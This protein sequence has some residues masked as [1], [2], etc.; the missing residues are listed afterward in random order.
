MF[1]PGKYSCIR[2]SS[3]FALFLRIQRFIQWLAS[4]VF[5]HRRLRFPPA[6]FLERIHN[7]PPPNSL[8]LCSNWSNEPSVFVFATSIFFSDKIFCVVDLSFEITDGEGRNVFDF[9]SLSWEITNASEE[10]WGWRKSIECFDIICFISGINV[11]SECL[12]VQS[13]TSTSGNSR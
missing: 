2:K 7:G 3:N 10:G 8:K 13:R 6:P 5:S 9:N 12:G 1:C 4:S 11:E